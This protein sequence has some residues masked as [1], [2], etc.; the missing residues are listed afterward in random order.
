MNL[1]KYERSDW[2][3]KMTPMT[4]ILNVIKITPASFPLTLLPSSMI[5]FMQLYFTQHQKVFQTGLFLLI[6]ITS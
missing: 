4:F 2:S 6:T 3:Y 5:H 1:I